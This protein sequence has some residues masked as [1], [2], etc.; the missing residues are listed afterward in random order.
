MRVLLLC[1]FATVTYFM[2]GRRERRDRGREG[3]LVEGEYEKRGGKRE[4]GKKGGGM[5]ERK[6]ERLSDRNLSSFN[7]FP[8]VRFST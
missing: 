6:R 1:I 7:Y 2:M 4:R 5:G 8:C 3:K